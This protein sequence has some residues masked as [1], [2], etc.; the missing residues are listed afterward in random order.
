MKLIISS[1]GVVG[2]LCGEECETMY[3]ITTQ[4]ITPITTTRLTKG[5]VTC[6]RSSDIHSVTNLS[7]HL[8]I[9]I[10]VY[11]GYASLFLSL[12]LLLS[13]LCE[14]DINTVTSALCREESMIYTAERRLS[15]Y[16]GIH[17]DHLHFFF[18]LLLLLFIIHFL[19]LFTLTYRR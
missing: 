3:D 10:H 11:G 17:Q 5:E 6:I 4:P 8:S 14:T 1:S 18:S 19:L 16:L 7:S 12:F 2:Q 15:L 13:H 9:S